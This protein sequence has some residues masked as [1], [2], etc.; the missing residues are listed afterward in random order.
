MRNTH[1]TLF[2]KSAERGRLL[3]PL[4][5]VTLSRG[6]VNA[7]NERVVQQLRDRFKD[8][9]AQPEIQ[10]IASIKKQM[11]NPVVNEIKKSEDESIGEFVDIWYSEETWSKLKKIKI[12][13]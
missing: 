5:T 10:S 9:E 1:K 13:T 11:R 3:G 6:K 4:A 12:H 2:K 7:I 8:L